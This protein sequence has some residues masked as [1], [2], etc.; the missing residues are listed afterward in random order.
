MGGISTEKVTPNL[1]I[2]NVTPGMKQRIAK[3]GKFSKKD[4]HGFKEGG[5]PTK[6][7]KVEMTRAEAGNYLNWSMEAIDNIVQKA[8]KPGGV[9]MTHNE[10]AM[11]QALVGDIKAL[12]KSLGY[13]VKPAQITIRLANKIRNRLSSEVLERVPPKLI[14]LA[15]IM[16]QLQWVAR[17]SLLI[18]MIY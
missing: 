15:E 17:V 10:V 3:S 18:S 11:T 16:L 9:A 6:R 8:Q 12:Q 14:S 1:Y 2:S 5:F 4:I 7:T 13:E